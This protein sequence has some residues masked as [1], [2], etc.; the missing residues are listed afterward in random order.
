MVKKFAG[1]CWT[2]LLIAI[3]TCLSSEPRKSTPHTPTIY[4]YDAFQCDQSTTSSIKWP[5]SFR[6]SRQNLIG[7][8][9][10]APPTTF[11]FIC[12]PSSILTITTVRDAS[13]YSVI[14]IFHLLSLCQFQTLAL[15]SMAL[16]AYLQASHLFLKHI[17]FTLSGRG[18]NNPIRRFGG[19]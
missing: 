15:K 14:S 19:F 16:L 9:L 3:L 18:S 10:H 4:L 13:H 7:C 2:R 11:S 6:R 17:C 5:L 12:S 8:V 1:F